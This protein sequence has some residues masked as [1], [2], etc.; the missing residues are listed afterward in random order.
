[1][2]EHP[3]WMKKQDLLSFEALYQFCDFMVQNGIEKIRIQGEN[4]Y[5]F[6]SC[7]FYP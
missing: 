4:P 1:M 2:P 7:S 3:E 5:A 6:R